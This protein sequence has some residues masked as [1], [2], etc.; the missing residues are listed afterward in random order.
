MGIV[1]FIKEVLREESELRAR[2][3]ASRITKRCNR[4]VDKSEINSLLYGYENIFF[5]M[6]SDHKWS[7][8]YRKEDR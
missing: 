8:L 2:E 1:E 7:L 4:V 3:I 6:S 5:E